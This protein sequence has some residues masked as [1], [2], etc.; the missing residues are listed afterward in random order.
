MSNPRVFAYIIATVGPNYKL[1]G[2][3]PWAKEGTVFFGPCKK[4]MRPEMEVGD[5]VMG[6]SP[7]GVGEQRRVLLWMRVQ[8]KLTF[9]QAYKRGETDERFRLARGNAIHVLPRKGVDTVEGDPDTYEHIPHAT[10]SSDWRT[11]IEGRKDAFFVGDKDSWVA[12]S[13]GPIVTE[14]LVELLREGIKWRGHATVHNPLTE[15]PRGK[16]ALLTGEAARR[17]IDWVPEPTK[18]MLSSPS[19]TTCCHRKCACE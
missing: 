13:Q 12:E 2:T 11:D 10:H 3:V 19:K 15:N 6:I 14:E 7:A 5:Y 9:A 18:R 4:N 16:H 8:E 1:L 17:V